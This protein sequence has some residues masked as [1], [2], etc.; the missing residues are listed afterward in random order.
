M[1]RSRSFGAACLALMAWFAA[2]IE[3]AYAQPAD[4]PTQ[5]ITIVVAFAAGG[6][7][8][9]SARI[10]GEKLHERWGQPVVVENR[11]GAA[12]NIAS[13]PCVARGARRATPR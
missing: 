6:S 7:T 11:L 4:D 8:D 5:R 9:A 10:I 1:L 12:G 3:H 13:G 2:G